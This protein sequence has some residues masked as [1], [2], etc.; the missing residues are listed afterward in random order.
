MTLIIYS[1]QEENYMKLKKVIALTLVA[2]VFATTALTGCSSKKS[3]GEKSTAETNAATS[4]E[5]ASSDGREKVDGVMYK[6]G[7][8]IVDPG[9]Y[10]FS[11]F[12]DDASETGQYYMM[13]ELQ[14]QT[15]VTVEL[16]QYPYDVAKEKYSLALSSGDYADCIGGWTVLDSDVLTYG[17]DM[18][19]FIPLEDYFEKYCPNITAMLNLEGVRE[20]MTAP[21]GH[22]YSIPYVLEAPEVDFN[23]YINTKW[24][25]NLGLEMPKTTE[26]LRTVLK[27]FKEKDANGN[28]DPNDEIPFAFDPDNRHLGYLCGWF[29]MSVDN[30]GFTMVD[31]KLTF[32]ANS[33]QFKNGIKFLNSLYK[34]GLLDQEMFTQ[35]K[36]QWKAKGSQ[37]LYGVSMMYGSGDIMPYDAGVTPDWVPLSVLS[38]EDGSTPVYLKSTYGTTVLK[39]QVV[40]TDNA[41]NPEAIC[42][43]WDNVMAMDNS[44]QINCGPL[45]KVV[46]KEG[47]G[48]RA[49]DIKTL[50]EEE[51]TKYN[52]SNLWP[53]S[54][55]K[56]LPK[57]FALIEDVPM[58]KEKPVVDKQYEPF[59]TK[60]IIPTYWANAE[61]ASSMA[62]LQTSIKN[63]LDQKI[64]EWVS[65]QEDIDKGWDS[66]IKQ[67][68][69]LGLQQYIEMRNKALEQ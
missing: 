30:Y 40:I 45:D 21:D 61:D 37:D 33:E 52:W 14:K 24:L 1:K 49:I 22:I 13:D 35:D 65:G 63:Y 54:L 7:L 34:E 2:S 6:E 4:T 9:S 5:T 27:A 31:D 3:D 28:G 69:N 57:G 68:D 20:A 48:Y 42:R 29:G 43:W 12:V 23:P 46:F 60:S 67:L 18:K 38:A 26:E 19:T 41:K 58:F 47:D 10:T 62:E 56:Y 50:S 8:P 64:A 36:S 11:L 25:K 39:N 32:G 55:P 44:V 59:L 17:V 16:Q 66:Y 51:Q 53:Q 15:G